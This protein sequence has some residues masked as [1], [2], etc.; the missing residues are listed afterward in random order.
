M[1]K[2]ARTEKQ[3]EKEYFKFERGH[4][5]QQLMPRGHPCESKNIK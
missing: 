5:L 2:K 3:K 1:Q 4:S